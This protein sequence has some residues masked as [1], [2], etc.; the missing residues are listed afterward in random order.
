MPRATEKKYRVTPFKRRG[1]EAGLACAV[2]LSVGAL[3]SIKLL[4]VAFELREKFLSIPGTLLV[5]TTSGFWIF[6]LVV[7]PAFLAGCTALLVWNLLRGNKVDRVYIGGLARFIFIFTLVMGFIVSA[8]LASYAAVRTNGVAVRGL[9]TGFNERFYPWDDV[10][11]AVLSSDKGGS[12]FQG[13]SA[14]VQYTL[15]LPGMSI[16]LLE[17]GVRNTVEK[18]HAIH[19]V[20][21]RNHVPFRQDLEFVD[22]HARDLIQRIEQGESPTPVSDTQSQPK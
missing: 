7:P 14:R 22:E 19:G 1:L 17:G 11:R 13:E 4:G 10:R 12:R 6:C 9:M 3:V 8:G 15:Y 5:T 16:E 18:V 21:L 20:I 2:G